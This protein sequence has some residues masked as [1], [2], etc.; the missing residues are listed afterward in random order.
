MSAYM[1]TEEWEDSLGIAKEQDMP[2]KIINK[3]KFWIYIM[4]MTKSIPPVWIAS[5]LGLC[6]YNF[7]NQVH[8]VNFY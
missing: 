1:L 4:E 7:S 2:K 3:W 5:Q 8:V 6:N